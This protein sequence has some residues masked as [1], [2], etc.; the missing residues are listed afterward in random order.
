MQ[1]SI[2]I[3][4]YNVKDFLE[5]CLN[6]VDKA[7]RNLSTEVFVV[8][9]NSVDQSCQMVKSKF[10]HFTL[11]E[12]KKNTGF[13][14][15]N[16]Q[17]IKLAKG[18]YIL[19]L[20][21]DTLVEEDTFEKVVG[22]MDSH[23]EAGGLGVKMIDGNGNF[24]PE[25]KRALPTPKVAFYKIFGLSKLFPNS[26]KFGQ[27]H[28]SFLDLNQTHEV[29]IL[30]G[31]FMLM[32]KEAL[33]KVGLLDETFFM[34][35]EDID[36]SYRIIL[37]GYKNYYFA[38]TTIIHYKGE[39]TKKSSLNYVKTFYNAM[40]IFAQKHFG[41]SA[42]C[43]I[44][45]IKAAVY[46]RAGI[47]IFKRIASNIYLPTIDFLVLTFG[48]WSLTKL[49]EQ[50]QY[51][52]GYYPSS[53]TWIIIPA[54]GLTY[55]LSLSIF[56]AYFKPVQF[57]KLIRGV[58]FG[59]VL[60]LAGYAL[61]DEDVRLSRFLILSSIAWAFLTLPSYRWFFH[62]LSF[63]PFRYKIKYKKKMI[64]VGDK[65]ESE[66][67]ANIVR[68]LQEQPE[69]KG[70]VQSNEIA[71]EG[72]LGSISQLFEIVRVH[73]IDEVIFCAKNVS[74]ADIISNMLDLN[75]LNCDT[76]IAS[77]DSIS[78][79]GSSS[80]NT[81]G[82]LY[83]VDLNLINS[84]ENKR[85][86]RVLDL[87]IALTLMISSPIFLLIQDQKQN[88]FNNLLSVIL[89]RKTFVGYTK[90]SPDKIHLPELKPCIIEVEDQ[91]SYAKNYTL[92]FDLLS[93][94]KNIRKIG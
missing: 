93:I 28:L 66:R 7:I 44:N 36:L 34:Y 35:G 83:H 45:L 92:W 62:Q 41:K 80:A 47:A 60:T 25:S 86:K 3:V 17:A 11:I 38:D 30:S 94:W 79:I 23:P 73:Q 67:V 16:N 61:L 89:N 29:E 85:N 18:E 76:K 59:G 12:N 51:H 64:I 82:T 39:S 78:V 21:P 49:W 57:T 87:L 13:A 31:A 84:E 54:I 1:L 52:S 77:P 58:A 72:S 48:F 65:Q 50:Y 5:Q 26:K 53:I 91:V 6:S 81:N 40:I 22:F 42:S 15:A 2:I 8:D 55:L 20:N 69:I 74:S 27:Y 4:N 24:L 90:L 10:P 33:D 19:L 46:L 88:F 37:G 14:V 63:I 71:Y 9:N 43:L 75:P 32:R 70:Y 68:A 56:G